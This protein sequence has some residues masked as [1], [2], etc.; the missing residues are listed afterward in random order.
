MKTVSDG[1]Y[2]GA[3]I[4]SMAIGI[5]E[6]A[7]RDAGIDPDDV[8]VSACRAADAATLSWSGHGTLQ[9]WVGD[10][11]HREVAVTVERLRWL[12]AKRDAAGRRD[13]RFEDL[14]SKN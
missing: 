9:G 14:F 3:G 12:A 1:A 11:V 13:E 8:I 10:H 4:R 2:L 7:C 5:A 6:R